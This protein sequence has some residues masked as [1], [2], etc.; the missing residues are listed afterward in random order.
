VVLLSQT[1]LLAIFIH[2]N[3]D[4]FVGWL[5]SLL[6]AERAVRQV[7]LILPAGLPKLEEPLH[8]IILL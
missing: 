5:D 7:V 1:L 2:A 8:S 3:V 6:K 4:G